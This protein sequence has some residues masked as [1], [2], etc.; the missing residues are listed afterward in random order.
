M[1]RYND[2]SNEDMYKYTAL[3]GDV[4]KTLQK[5]RRAVSLGNR[6]FDGPIFT[7]STHTRVPKTDQQPKIIPV[8]I[9]GKLVAKSNE[10]PGALQTKRNSTLPPSPDYTARLDI[11][12]THPT[13][14]VYKGYQI[15]TDTTHP[16]V[17]RS[18]SS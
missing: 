4:V 16:V 10:K 1:S 11:L 2:I 17:K 13:K 6:I 7:S 9:G 12:T 3:L 8:M 18:L 15:G 14:P 5:N